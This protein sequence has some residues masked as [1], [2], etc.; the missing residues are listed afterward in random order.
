MPE[1][2]FWHGRGVFS[3]LEDYLL[4]TVASERKSEAFTTFFEEDPRW[5]WIAENYG[6]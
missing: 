1:Y 5:C 6:R 2:P 4:S 3:E